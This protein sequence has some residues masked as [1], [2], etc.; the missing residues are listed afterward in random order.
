MSE[1]CKAASLFKFYKRVFVREVRHVS[2]EG[3]ETGR[4]NP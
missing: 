3:F 2:K 1:A 4:K